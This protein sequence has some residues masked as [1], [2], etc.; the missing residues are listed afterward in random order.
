MCINGFIFI[1]KYFLFKK[2]FTVKKIPRRIGIACFYAVVM[3]LGLCFLSPT[4]KHSI[5][6]STLLIAISKL[7]SSNV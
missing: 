5:F 2:E 3:I 1:L 7:A 6:L 4:V